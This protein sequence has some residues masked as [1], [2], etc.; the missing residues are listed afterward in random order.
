MAETKTI[1]TNFS[2]C[3]EIFEDIVSKPRLLA[4]ALIE[5]EQN[6]RTIPLIYHFSDCFFLHK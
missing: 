6:P 5:K 1:R 3:I 2:H 4:L